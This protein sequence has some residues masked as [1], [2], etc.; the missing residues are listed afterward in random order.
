MIFNKIKSDIDGFNDFW[1]S[2]MY[3]N[4][5]GT[6]IGYN[7][8]NK[9]AVMMTNLKFWLSSNL[10]LY[11]LLAQIKNMNKE[12]TDP[13][14]TCTVSSAQATRNA[15][16]FWRVY[17]N[18]VLEAKAFTEGKGAK[19]FHILHPTLFSYDTLTE[20]EKTLRKLRACFFEAKPAYDVYYYNIVNFFKDKPWHLNLSD[21]LK[22]Q[23]LYFD[24]AHIVP[25]GNELLAEKILRDE[26]FLKII[27]D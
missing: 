13:R 27:S 1:Q 19:F 2:S 20:Y 18:Y 16:E 3:G 5:H 17:V 10:A 14:K 21:D 7:I 6:I 15:S 11:N 8:Q 23:N 9:N 22:N 25:K 12:T 26:N 24:H 4:P